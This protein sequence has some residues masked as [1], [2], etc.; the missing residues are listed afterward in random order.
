M[1]PFRM[2]I[3]NRSITEAKNLPTRKR[4]AGRS[5]TITESVVVESQHTQGLLDTIAANPFNTTNY[6]ILADDAEESNAPHAAKMLR[7]S[8]A[9]IRQVKEW[10]AQGQLDQEQYTQAVTK[11]NRQFNRAINELGVK[12][13]TSEHEGITRVETITFNGN[14]ARV[15]I[16]PSDNKF[17]VNVRF[18]EQVMS[19]TLVAM[20]C[21]ILY[22]L[23]RDAGQ[24]PDLWD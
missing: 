15:I 10:A 3:T 1:Q 19:E 11:L 2:N 24:H 17:A 4:K 6:A 21:T 14:E 12:V 9:M 18:G 13:R 5:R 7:S 8:G 20:A 23:I 16:G 22:K